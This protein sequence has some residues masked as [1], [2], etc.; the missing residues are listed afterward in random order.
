MN[1]VR[2]GITLAG[3]QP[4]QTPLEP[5]LQLRLDLLVTWPSLQFKHLL[6]MQVKIW[7]L[8]LH[9][10]LLEIQFRGR[11]SLWVQS[12]KVG[13]WMEQRKANQLSL[14]RKWRKASTNRCQSLR[15][16]HLG[17]GIRPRT[18]VVQSDLNWKALR[19]RIH[20]RICRLMCRFWWVDRIQPQLLHLRLMKEIRH[21]HPLIRLHPSTPS[22]RAWKPIGVDGLH[23]S[24]RVPR[25]LKL[26]DMEVVVVFRMLRRMRMGW[27]LFTLMRTKMSEEMWERARYLK[28][29]D[30]GMVEGPRQF[31]SPNRSQLS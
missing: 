28:I 5:P 20:R 21:L 18:Q 14:Q 25:W 11:I 4:P 24:V 31:L 10:P 26:L 27:R 23:F 19:W 15:G 30:P 16:I 12:L 2:G 7:N 13:W 3:L 1:Q 29:L 8:Q 22:L 9:L 17:V 6:R